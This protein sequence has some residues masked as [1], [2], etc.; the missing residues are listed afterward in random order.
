MNHRRTPFTGL[1]LCL[2]ALLGAPHLVTGMIAR[3]HAAPTAPAEAVSAMDDNEPPMA[4]SQ[5]RPLDET[6]SFSFYGHWDSD[7]MNYL[8]GGLSQGFVFNSV[9]VAGAS[10]KGDALGL[11]HSVFD[12]SLMGTRTGFGAQNRLG[13]SIIDP[14]NIEG[15]RDRLVLNTAF[16]QQNW[17]NQPGLNLATRAGMFDLNA[18][19]INTAS[20]GLL[21]NSSFGLDPAMTGNFTTSTFPQNGTGVVAILDNRAAHNQTAPLTLKLGLIQGDVTHQTHPFNQGALTIAEGEWQPEAGSVYQLGIWQKH[22]NGQ[23][24]LHGSYLSAEHNLFTQGEQS[25]DGFVRASMASGAAG[26]VEITRYLSAGVNWQSP[27]VDRPDDYLTFG[28]GGVR[29]ASAGMNERLF[30]LAYLIKLNQHLYVQPDLQY[31]QHP[32]GTLPNAWVAIVRLHIE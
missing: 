15:N 31:I 18:D 26:S 30:E 29:R 3:A 32:N 9:A 24:S 10:F 2:I 23:P 8:S 17:L 7:A 1:L 28:A 27:W 20:A 5:P 16:W 13:D 11:A 6:D 4:A 25:L 19:F 12:V 21:L 14:S 22:G